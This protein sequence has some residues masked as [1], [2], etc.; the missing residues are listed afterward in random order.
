MR[1]VSKQEWEKKMSNVRLK[2]EDMN[3]LIMNFLVTEGYVDAAKLFQQESGTHPGV[4]L[5]TI[6]DRMHIRKAVQGGDIEEAIDLVND[7][8]PEILELQPQLSF[9]LQQQ[10][11]IE[12][13]RQGKVE[14]AL[15][16]A[17]EYLAPQG[18]G[19][20]AFLQE[21]ERTVALLAFENAASSPVADLMDA[22]QRQ[23]TASEVNAAILKSQHQECEARLPGLLKMMLWAQSQL[24]GHCT[25]PHITDLMSGTLSDPAAASE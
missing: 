4:D 13:V 12:L 3:A 25:F 19:N 1:S 8:N 23:K 9:H 24:D 2:K 17:Q 15:D 22:A 14:E 20:P 5:D 21:L 10:R 11:L 18:E 16:F 6:T 7:F